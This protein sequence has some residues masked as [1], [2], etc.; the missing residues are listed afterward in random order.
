MLAM[1]SCMAV[2]DLESADGGDGVSR[3]T[4]EG[5]APAAVVTTAEPQGFGDGDSGA[6]LASDGLPGRT[7]RSVTSSHSRGLAGVWEIAACRSL[8]SALGADGADVLASTVYVNAPRAFEVR[9]CGPGVPAY[10]TVGGR[11]TFLC[12]RFGRIADERAQV[13]LIH[14]AL[15]A[16][17]LDEYPH[18]PEGLNPDQI[19]A[20]VERS[21]GFGS[22]LRH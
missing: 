5:V 13:V 6:L 10:T 15:H 1:A 14:E 18:D 2:V 9:V 8:F 3:E 12:R 17:G 20:L 21:C 7:R 19:N 22:S 4:D 16:A 11:V